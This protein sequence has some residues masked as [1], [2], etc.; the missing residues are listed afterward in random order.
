MAIVF[1]SGDHAGCGEKSILRS[2]A[3]VTE[4]Y[5]RPLYHAKADRFR[6]SRMVP[7]VEY[8]QSQRLRSQMMMALAKATEGVDVYLAPSAFEAGFVSA[9]HSDADIAATVAAASA[10]F[11]LDIDTSSLYWANNW[12]EGVV[13]VM[14]VAAALA[15]TVVRSRL[16]A[17]L[18]LGAVGFSVAGLFVNLGAPDLVLTQLLVETVVVVGFVVGLGRLATTFPKPTRLWLS[19]RIVLSVLIGTAIALGLAASAARPSGEP[20]VLDLANSAVEDGGGNNVVNVI[21][22]DTRGLDTVGEAIVLMVVAV[23]ILT[24]TTKRRARGSGV[25]A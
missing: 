22:T 20:P 4:A 17:A 16:G 11:V 3:S 14:I 6:V 12:V 19:G 25:D 15:S 9:A 2:V 8:L 5:M 7:A 1:P 10:P 23:G 21:L 13:V 24:L 18:V